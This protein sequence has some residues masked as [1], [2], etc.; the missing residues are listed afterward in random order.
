MRA[1]PMPG[2]W[3]ELIAFPGCSGITE[4]T[5]LASLCPETCHPW[6]IGAILQMLASCIAFLMLFRWHLLCEHKP[7]PGGSHLNLLLFLD[8]L[9]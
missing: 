6:V 9:E 3:S 8:V 7:T 2:G 5:K 1:K 4:P